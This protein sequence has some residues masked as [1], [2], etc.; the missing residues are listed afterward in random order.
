MLFSLKSDNISYFSRLP[1]FSYQNAPAHFGQNG[2]SLSTRGKNAI[3]QLIG[4]GFFLAFILTQ[5]TMNSESDKAIF[6]KMR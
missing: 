5:T 1:N 6:T 4:V 2:W 3:S